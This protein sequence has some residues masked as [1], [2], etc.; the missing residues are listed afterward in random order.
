MSYVHRV[1]RVTDHVR[2]NLAGDLSLE[3]LAKVAYF[4]PF[5][6]HRIFK[7]ATGETV[8]QFTRRARLE[9]AAQLMMA[10]P[11]RELGSIGLEVGFASQSD[12]SRAFKRLY[13]VP[14]SAWDRRSRLDE[15]RIPPPDRP[16][17]TSP[18][19]VKVQRHPAVRLAY[20]RMNTPFIGQPLRDGYAKLTA[21]LDARG[22]DWRSS[23]LVGLGWG[24]HETTPL[25]QVMFDF[26]FAVP[27]EIEPEGEIG[28]HE[29]PELLAVDVRCRGGLP[30]IA[31][32]WDYLYEQW[33]PHSKYEPDDYP[34]MKRF[35][36]RPD[37]LGWRE[38]DLDCSVALRPLAP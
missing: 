23:A 14:P 32:A 3:A 38:Y 29:H 4:S 27:P 13:G 15:S 34:G 36:R 2:R 18:F 12:F 9:R 35:H 31:L 11:S 17:D 30:R 1:Q 16:P 25:D 33:L 5:H 22:F 21:W 24:N 26:G 20:I 37:E 8:A 10:A 7:A 28:I 19:E 6:F